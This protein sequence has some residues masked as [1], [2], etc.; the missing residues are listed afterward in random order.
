MH[1]IVSTVAITHNNWDR[2]ARKENRRCSFSKC[3]TNRRT[4]SKT[5]SFDFIYNRILNQSNLAIEEHYYQ[6]IQAIEEQKQKT[7]TFHDV[8]FHDVDKEY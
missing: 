5:F 3:L 8:V 7:H 6:E 1:G 4:E 2:I